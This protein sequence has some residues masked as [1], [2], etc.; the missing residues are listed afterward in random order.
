MRTC[1]GRRGFDPA[2]TKHFNWWYNWATHSHLQ[3]LIEIARTLK[4]RLG[5]ILT[6]LK[7]RITNAASESVNA[8]IQWVK[9][10][11]RGFRN[12]HNFKTPIYFRRG[13]L[14]MAPLPT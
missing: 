6:Y 4:T 8:K 5:N 14:H 13:I 10:T 1:E 12:K 9:Y 2:A 11:A 7:H 3:P